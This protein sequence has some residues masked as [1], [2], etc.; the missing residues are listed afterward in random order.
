MK[1]IF[2]FC[3]MAIGAGHVEFTKEM[4]NKY[5]YKFYLYKCGL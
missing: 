4:D 3:L 5:T 2:N 1:L